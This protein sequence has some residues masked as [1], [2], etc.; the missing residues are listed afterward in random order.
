MVE[1][2]VEIGILFDFYGKLLSEKQYLIVDLYYNHDLSLAEI[3]DELGITKQGVSDILKRAED[4]LYNFEKNL[5]LVKKFY[6]S[7][8]NIKKILDISQEI[9]EVAKEQNLVDIYNKSLKIKEL[10]KRILSS[11]REVID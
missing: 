4:K 10:S 3:G 1:K 9:M 2:L 7:H 11:S 5:G 6:S 8:N